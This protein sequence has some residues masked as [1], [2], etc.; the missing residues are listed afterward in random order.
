MDSSV[1]SAIKAAKYNEAVVVSLSSTDDSSIN[2]Q[3][4]VL[5][6]R[7][8]AVNGGVTWNQVQASDNDNDHDVGIV[9]HLRTKRWVLPMLNDHCRNNLYNE[10]IREASKEAVK[11]LKERDAE[12]SSKPTVHALDIGSGT[13]LLAMMAARHLQT[14]AQ[15][16]SEI[17]TTSEV[18]LPVIT[19]TSL[20]MSSAM[21]RL[22]RQTIASNDLE[23][24]IDVLEA[25]S[26]DVTLEQKV[27]LC[28]SELLD[29][30]LLGEGV[31]P[32]LRDAWERHLHAD[33]VVVP[34][35]ARIFAQVLEGRECVG[36]YWGPHACGTA[37]TLRLCLSADSEDV[38]IG[39]AHG[40][41]IVPLHCAKLFAPNGKENLN[42]ESFYARSLCEPIEVLSFS[43]LSDGL[44]DASGRCQ[45]TSF[46]PSKS[47]VAHGVLFWWELDL[48]D[49]LVYSTESGK[50]PWQDH[51][52]QC[53]YVF[54]TPDS[55]CS[56]LKEGELK[57][58]E[59]RHDD[60]RISFE[61]MAD[62]NQHNMPLKRHRAEALPA[63]ISPQRAFQL[64][65]K[66]RISLLRTAM[67]FA[68]A[69]KGIDTS[70]VDLSDFALCAMLAALEGALNVTSVESSTGTL[71]Q[72]SARVAQL[73][74]GLPR[75]GASFQI[76]QC[77]PEQLTID[78]IPGLS[79][80]PVGIVVAEPYF[81]VLEGWHLQEA[82]N[83]FY[84]VRAL[85]LRGVMDETASVVPAFALIKGA[86]VNCAELWK[87]Y[88][89]CGDGSEDD[90]V[91]G[92]KHG[93][94][95]SYGVPFENHDMCVPS[96]Q[97]DFTRLT[98]TF[99][100]GRL[101]FE[102]STCTFGAERPVRVPF[103]KAGICHGLMVRSLHA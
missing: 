27:H 85:R 11:K 55:E 37:E 83:F 93:V 52:Q 53:L 65:D 17:D 6:A 63:A 56:K 70:V 49:G 68:V 89:R 34:Q 5:V 31:I 71:A 51:W 62:D 9:Q 20:E 7:L 88:T 90:R 54:P 30:G 8:D 87:A 2:T 58:L 84:L 24:I 35:R 22:A 94:V 1:E 64:N 13:G 18:N 95:N 10:A 48:W 98:E 66:N 60:S 82:M 101:S 79:D 25:H 86:A 77:H 73:A 67:A 26:F 21:A 23:Q 103:S 15:L 99:E 39:G 40:E 4:I 96:W 42:D 3:E 72:S 32:A 57:S 45:T 43:F 46:I 97:Y 59:V 44:P 14:E 19:V 50:Q 80:K 61:I 41:I 29:S 81:E 78:A 102:E 28:T 100:L 91:C 75:S 74:N 12:S 16:V 76:L 36:N 33:A 69:E 38:M 92:F 47:G